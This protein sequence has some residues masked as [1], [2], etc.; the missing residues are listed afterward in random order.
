MLEKIGN[1]AAYLIGGMVVFAI[2]IFFFMTI[3]GFDYSISKWHIA[4]WLGGSVIFTVWMY[5]T[6]QN[7][8]KLD[9]MIGTLAD[10]QRYKLEIF[11]WL[12]MAD[13]TLEDKEFQYIKEF[14]EKNTDLTL[15]DKELSEL[16]KIVKK[17]YSTFSSYLSNIREN[18]SKEERVEL[19]KLAY[20]IASTD[21]KISDGIIASEISR[22]TDLKV[23]FLLSENDL[24]KESIPKNI[25]S[26]IENEISI[27]NNPGM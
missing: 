14:V 7:K 9:S 2:A 4:I 26:A 8:S 21:K 1:L 17:S 13:N 16:I 15:T 3:D 27:R 19:F 18:I 24:E 10:M 25:I 11:C 22:L 23:E 5:I 20:T 6:D 12:A